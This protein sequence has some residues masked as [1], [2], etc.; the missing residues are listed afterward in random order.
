MVSGTLEV[1]LQSVEGE[2]VNGEFGFVTEGVPD[3]TDDESTTNF[4]TYDA[5]LTYDLEA[6]DW[7]AGNN[8][9]YPIQIRAQDLAGNLLTQNV[10]QPLGGRDISGTASSCA[11]VRIPKGAA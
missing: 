2:E 3:A 8:A 10:M 5:T 1:V 9:T 6:L 7:P 11:R 4:T